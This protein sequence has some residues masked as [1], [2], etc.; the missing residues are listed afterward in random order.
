RESQSPYPCCVLGLAAQGQRLRR[1]RGGVISCERRG[2]CRG[3]SPGWCLRSGRDGF[4][5]AVAGSLFLGVHLAQ[6]AL[7]FGREDLDELAACRG[8][9][10]QQRLG[11][12]GTGVAEV[13]LD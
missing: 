2:G 5:V 1:P 8:P 6:R 3:P 11:A 4:A 7:V 10:R 12:L 13:L 9:V